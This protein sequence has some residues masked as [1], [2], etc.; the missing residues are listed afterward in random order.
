MKEH[1]SKAKFQIKF[2]FLYFLISNLYCK[3]IYEENIYDNIIKKQFI[4]EDN[5]NK[6]I[7]YLKIKYLII[8]INK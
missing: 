6:I 2:L 5:K 4:Q 8:N 1:L 7:T 3:D